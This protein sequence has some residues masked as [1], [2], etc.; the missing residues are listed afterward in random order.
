MKRPLIIGHRG[1]SAYAPENT[2]ASFK[3]ALAL[4]A[5]GLEIDVQMSKDG[6]LVIC[7]DERVDRTTDGTGAIQALT[8][9]ELQKLDAGSWFSKEFKGEKIPVLEDLL[10]CL[11]GRNIL[12]N[13][14]LKNGIVLYEGLEEKIL[15]A[16]G[17]YRMEHCTVLSSFNHYSLLKIK[18]L[19]PRIKVGILYVAGMVRPWEYARSI[20]ADG[21]HPIYYSVRP[22]IVAGAQTHQMPIYTY[23][24]NEIS[25]LE[26]I[27]GM[28]VAGIITDYPDRGRNAVDK[29]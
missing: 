22:E 17:I 28:E 9:K 5:D 18:G 15:E 11:R 21:L 1:A 24:V 20:G 8:L 13:I 12:L 19:N 3:K 2:M 29:I 10:D 23:T 27:A 14:E 6:H 4:G 7:H 26:K 16:L 25:D